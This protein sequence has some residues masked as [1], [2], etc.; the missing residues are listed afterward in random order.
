MHA[1]DPADE[2]PHAPGPDPSWHESWYADFTVGD[3]TRDGPFGAFVELVLFP[4]VPRAL[5]LAAVAGRDRPLVAL[6]EYDA[7]MPRRDS[8]ELRGPG[9]WL[10]VATDYPLE[11][12]T[13]ALEAFALTFDAPDDA[14]G[15]PRG[16]RT[17]FGLDLEWETA[18]E[19]ASPTRAV[20]GGYELTCAVRGEVLIGP[21]QITVDARGTRRHTW[22]PTWHAHAGHVGTTAAAE[23]IARVPFDVPTPGVGTRVHR[24]LRRATNGELLWIGE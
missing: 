2:A 16:A 4:N 23:T 24:S 15:D 6:L 7:P 11:Q 12:F 5:F 8:L 10:D 20:D 22:G 9:L 21:E 17:P 19:P 14:L 18:S 13:V 3:E 1:V